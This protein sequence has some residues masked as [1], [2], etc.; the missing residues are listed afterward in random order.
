MDA[1]V[2]N[3]AVNWTDG[4]GLQVVFEK[5]S[6][7]FS[8]RRFGVNVDQ[9]NKD[10]EAMERSLEEDLKKLEQCCKKHPETLGKLGVCKALADS[11]K[12]YP[13]RIQP[14]D[15]RNRGD[16]SYQ[17]N[18]RGDFINWPVPQN[19]PQ[20]TQ[21]HE[22]YTG[23]N[24]NGE[25]TVSDQ[26]NGTLLAH[27]FEHFATDEGKSDKPS[28]DPDEFPNAGDEAAVNA[29]NQIRKCCPEFKG[30]LRNSYLPPK[31]IKR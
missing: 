26:L 9:W 10:F 15:W 7:D 23:P 29:E 18:K 22:V 1:F 31:K 3:G 25:Y 19:G 5:P 16:A 8:N 24:T 17:S 14:R 28:S 21:G 11:D 27:E 30:P 6:Y 2:A 13:I 4:L 20:A 12:K